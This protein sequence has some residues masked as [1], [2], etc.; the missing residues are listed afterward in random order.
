MGGRR[1]LDAT[2]HGS[3]VAPELAHM[4]KCQPLDPS[5]SAGAAPYPGRE[6]REDTVRDKWAGRYEGPDGI[7][8][9]I[10]VDD[11]HRALVVDKRGRHEKNPPVFLSPFADAGDAYV[12]RPD[13]GWFLT[14]R[15]A[16]PGQRRPR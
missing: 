4:A 3:R 15:T 10:S 16:S 7:K 2:S 1:A 13:G 9:P 12:V 5:T 14:T 11:H 8:P 6:C